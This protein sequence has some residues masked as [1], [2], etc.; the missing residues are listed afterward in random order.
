MTEVLLIKVV[1]RNALFFSTGTELWPR[2]M[3]SNRYART[4]ELST[5]INKY[6]NTMAVLVYLVSWV[7]STTHICSCVGAPW[8][9]FN[10]AI[11]GIA[12]LVHARICP[13][14]TTVTLQVFNG[15]VSVFPETLYR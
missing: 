5:H 1:G 7:K 13:G 14:M 3:T 4:Q 11:L 6:V 2:N 8:Y 15:S 9:Y 12:H 10:D